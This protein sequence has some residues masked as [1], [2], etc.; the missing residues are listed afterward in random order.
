MTDQIADMLTRIRNA[1]KVRKAEVFIPF[2]KIK[3]EIVKILKREKFIEN[4]REIKPDSEYK[5]GGIVVELK[6]Q[7]RQ[8]AISSLKKI[9]KPGR[10][11][12]AGRKELPTVLN[13]AGIAIISTPAGVMT[14][15][16]AKK[17]DLGGEVICEI[18]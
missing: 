16:Q 17:K 9:S 1:S 8:P 14:A 3:L 15:G 13:G 5:F 18:Y 7:E 10:R 4:F 11:V 6:Y 12:Y 2:S